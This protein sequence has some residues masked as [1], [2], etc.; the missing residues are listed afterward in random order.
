VLR[1]LGSTTALAALNH[2]LPLSRSSTWVAVTMLAV[3]LLRGPYGLRCSTPAASA[4]VCWREF[5]VAAVPGLALPRQVEH[6]D[7]AVDTSGLSVL[8]S[9]M[10]SPIGQADCA[11]ARRITSDR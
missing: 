2:L 9:S 3:G 1:A 5:R 8:V 6:L 4:W 7:G 11:A 10:L